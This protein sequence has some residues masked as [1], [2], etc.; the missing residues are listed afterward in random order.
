[1][2]F[3]FFLS[4][5]FFTSGVPISFSF[6]LSVPGPRRIKKKD[7]LYA[8]LFSRSLVRAAVGRQKAYPCQLERHQC[9]HGTLGARTLRDDTRCTHVVQNST[10]VDIYWHA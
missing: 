1:M 2:F 8:V 7:F 6:F 5:F 9:A 10:R 4:H 3:P